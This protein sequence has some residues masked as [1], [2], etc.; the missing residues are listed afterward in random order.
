MQLLEERLRALRVENNLRQDTLAN[1]LNCSRFSISNYENGRSITNDIIVS[2]C[3]YFHVSADWL[4]GLTTDRNPGGSDLSAKLE[5]LASLTVAAGGDPLTADQLSALLD[6]YIR[7]YQ[8]GAPAGNTPVSVLSAVLLRMGVALS[9]LM[10]DQIAPVLA[11]TNDV[12][13]AGLDAQ[14]MLSAWLE[15]NAIRP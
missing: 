14:Q 4:L 1:S 6:A 10:G 2:Y 3:K 11:A 7:Y 13:S 5:T 12:A 9:A 8:H 15:H